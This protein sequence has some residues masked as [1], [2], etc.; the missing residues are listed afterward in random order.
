M[1]Q[2]IIHLGTSIDN[3]DKDRLAQSIRELIPSILGIDEKTGQVLLYDSSH[4][5]IHATRDSNFVFV[6]V[7]MYT[8][9]SLELKAK[10]ATAIIAEI[11]K[12]TGV[13]GNDINLGFYELKPDNYFGGISHK[14]I[15]DLGSK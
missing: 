1:P 12:Y 6:Q 13:D 10:L 3:G 15:E 4:R 8:G 14:Y 2:V 7:T 11:H 9:R 5:A